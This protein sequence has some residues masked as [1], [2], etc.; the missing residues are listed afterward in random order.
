MLTYN[1]NWMRYKLWADGDTLY[2]MTNVQ[3]ED[4]T[5]K[6]ALFQC[7]L[8]DMSV[9]QVWATPNKDEVGEW[10]TTGVDVSQWYV[11]DGYI[12]F[13][14]S[15]GDMWRSELATSKLEKLAD[16]HEKTQYGSAVFSDEYMCLLNDFP[17][18]SYHDP[19]PKPGSIFRSFGD[20]IYIYGLDGTFIKDI[21]IKP[22]YDE[23]DSVSIINM[24]MCDSTDVY[25]LVTGYTFDDPNRPNL[26]TGRAVTLCRANIETGEVGVLYKLI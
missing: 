25:F 3:V 9:K 16:T 12:Y 11:T 23:L 7:D 21:S 6:D 18:V 14:L 24:L 1:P 2:F 26:S 8:T 5:N 4:G 13:Y 17:A 15:G 20:T 19:T 10:E 22:I